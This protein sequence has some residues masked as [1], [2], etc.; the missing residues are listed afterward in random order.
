MVVDETLMSPGVA[1]GIKLTTAR[2]IATSSFL[3][4]FSAEVDLEKF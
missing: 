3:L 2:R 4:E 1:E